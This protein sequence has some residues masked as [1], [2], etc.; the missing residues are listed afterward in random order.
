MSE[1]K[2]DYFGYDLYQAMHNGNF[3]ERVWHKTRLNKILN[4]FDYSG[5][6][7]LE[8]GCNAGPVMIPLLKGGHDVTG[9]DISKE[10]ILKAQEYSK[11]N[12]IEYAPLCV[13]NALALP[14]KNETF[15]IALMIDLFEHTSNPQGIADECYRILKKNGKAF[16][17]FKRCLRFLGKNKSLYVL[18]S[19]DRLS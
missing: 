3:F 7:I 6:K 4:S 2:K 18:G 12:N 11:E 9:I 17:A 19:E 1:I 8:I 5:K 10:D 15:D 14:F 16:I 13:S